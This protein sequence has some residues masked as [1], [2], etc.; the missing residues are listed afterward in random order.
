MR[1]GPSAR[2]TKSVDRIARYHDLA[3][4]AGPMRE[5]DVDLIIPP[6]PKL[7]LSGVRARTILIWLR[8]F[9]GVIPG[10]KFCLTGKRLPFHIGG[11]RQTQNLEDRG[12]DIGDSSAA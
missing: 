2:R 7:G 8:K 9:F 1:K 4:Q 11:K 3:A 5:E 10:R 6:P 12:C